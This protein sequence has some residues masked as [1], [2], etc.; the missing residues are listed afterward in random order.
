[1]TEV[2]A[3]DV[4]ELRKITGCALMECKKALAA[5]KGDLVLAQ[6]KMKEAGVLK[7]AKKST[8]ATLEGLIHVATSSDNTKAIMLEVKCETDFVGK[9]NNFVEFVHNVANHALVKGIGNVDELLSS[10]IDDNNTV[11]SLRQGLVLKIGENIQV[12]RLSYMAAPDSGVVGFYVHSGKIGSLVSLS[13]KEVDLGR[14]L[15]MHIT[16]NRPKAIGE[17]DFPKEELANERSSYMAQ[18]SETGKPEDIQLKMVEG[19]MKK[20]L[21]EHSLLEQQFVKDNDVKVQDLLKKANAEV[22]KFV[23]YALGEV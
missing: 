11:E 18:A 5:A 21:A 4:M 6:Q 9:D 3:K 8:R 23:C 2:S 22:Q 19:R 16:A 13:A 7:A 12:S 10:Q 14:D 17:A 15:A 20:Y 1:M